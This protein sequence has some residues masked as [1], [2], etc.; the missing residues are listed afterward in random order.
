[1]LADQ[2]PAACHSLYLETVSRWPGN[3]FAQGSRRLIR[4]RFLVTLL[5]GPQVLFTDRFSQPSKFFFQQSLHVVVATPS[6]NFDP[7]LFRQG[8][9]IRCRV[10]HQPG[11]RACQGIGSWY[12]PGWSRAET[13][14]VR[15]A[16]KTDKGRLACKDIGVIRSKQVDK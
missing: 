16:D 1:G 9:S 2:S 10:D 14:T 8:S 12:I 13:R 7:R 5:P 6:E 4:S 15:V 11:Q 3:R